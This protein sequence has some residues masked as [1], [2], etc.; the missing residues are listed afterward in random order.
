M[1]EG[2]TAAHQ[3]STMLAPHPEVARTAVDGVLTDDHVAPKSVSRSLAQQFVKRIRIASPA[4]SASSTAFSL[5]TEFKV[6]LRPRSA[7]SPAYRSGQ[8]Q[9]EAFQA[10]PYDLSIASPKTVLSRT[11][12]RLAGQARQL[13]VSRMTAHWSRS[14]PQTGIQSFRASPGTS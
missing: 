11:F 9:E 12:Q 8:D 5:R 1:V 14:G 2:R 13:K 6:A 4:S 3:R 7:A 10:Y